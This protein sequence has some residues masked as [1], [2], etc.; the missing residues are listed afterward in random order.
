MDGG[1]MKARALLAPLLMLSK[2][3]LPINPLALTPPAYVQ[4]ISTVRMLRELEERTGRQIHELFDLIV[5][6]STG[7]L[8]AVAVG[9]RKLSLDECDHIYK[10]LG[11]KVGV[12]GRRSHSASPCVGVAV[13]VL[14]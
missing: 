8:L 7:G 9:L 10:V 12:A 2:T 13:S 6:T 1:G 4:G 14:C 11:Q 5:G 3:L